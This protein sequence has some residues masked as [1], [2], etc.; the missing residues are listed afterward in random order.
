LGFVISGIPDGKIASG[1]C[2]NII[3]IWDTKEVS[4]KRTLK[5]HMGK[6]SS[7]IVLKI[8]HLA[9]GSEDKM[10]KIWNVEEERELRTIIGHN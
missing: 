4:E 5:G 9:S 8:G 10:I 7:L 2:D 1:S 6:V 3:K